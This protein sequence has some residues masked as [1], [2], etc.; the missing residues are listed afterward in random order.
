[1]YKSILSDLLQN[2][3]TENILKLK[4][5]S[6]VKMSFSWLRPPKYVQ[7]AIIISVGGVLFGYA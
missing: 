1:M 7:A 3:Y 4:K 5:S 6:K 2:H